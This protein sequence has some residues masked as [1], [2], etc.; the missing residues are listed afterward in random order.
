MLVA[1][2]Q[3]EGVGLPSVALGKDNGGRGFTRLRGRR[4]HHREVV[5]FGG[6]TFIHTRR[7]GG[8][9]AVRTGSNNDGGTGVEVRLA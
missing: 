7:G 5:G 1:V 9:A 2:A 8:D 6:E 3:E 4:A